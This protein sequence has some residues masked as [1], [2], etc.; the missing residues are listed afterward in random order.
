[1]T[2]ELNLVMSLGCNAL[3]LPFPISVCLTHR[4]ATVHVGHVETSR[5]SDPVLHCSVPH[6]RGVAALSRSDK[7]LNPYIYGR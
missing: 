5:Q 3:V 2:G 1:M 7:N 6:T 4:G